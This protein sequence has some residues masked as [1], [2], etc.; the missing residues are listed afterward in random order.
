MEQTPRIEIISLTQGESFAWREFI[1]PRFSSPWHFHSE[2]ELTLI[3]HGSGQLF[4]GDQIVPFNKGDL[5]MLGGGLPHVFYSDATRKIQGKQAHSHAVVIQMLPD[6]FG[7]KFWEIQENHD[8]RVLLELSRR[9]ISFDAAARPGMATLIEEIGRR[10]GVPRTL[11]LLELLNSCSGLLQHSR[12]LCSEGYVSRPDVYAERRINTVCKYVFEGSNGPITLAEAARRA[13]MN[14]SAFCRYF[15][16]VTGKRFMTFVN[17][18]RVG[19]VCRALLETQGGIAEIAFAC[20]FGSL[21]NFNRWFGA[22]H[23]MSP[24]RFR[25][26]HQQLKSSL[27]KKQ[28]AT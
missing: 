28:S 1:E 4:V 23:G 16:K 24:K 6:V 19:H 12:L 20:G 27:A 25:S 26:A 10:K 8:L 15:G 7:A 13:A 14:P 2:F 3:R 5:F 11:A 9:G 21:S 22:A 17:E 18:V